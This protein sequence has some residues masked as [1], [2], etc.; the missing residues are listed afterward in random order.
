MPTVTH[1]P[2]GSQVALTA[3]TGVLAMSAQILDDQA[4]LE[5]HDQ[6]CCAWIALAD[7]IR[8]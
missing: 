3:V 8:K 5:T 6:V 1:T 7:T 4:L 2:H